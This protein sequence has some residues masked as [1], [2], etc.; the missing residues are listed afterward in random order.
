MPVRRTS[1][2]FNTPTHDLTV[3]PR[4]KPKPVSLS[5]GQACDLRFFAAKVR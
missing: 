1:S 5:R 2:Y 3:E 4:S